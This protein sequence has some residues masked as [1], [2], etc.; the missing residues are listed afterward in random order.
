MITE[1]S[2]E[3]MLKVAVAVALVFGVRVQ[4][5]MPLQ[6]PDQP[7]NVDPELAFAVRVK[8]APEL[9]LAVHVAPQLI[10]DGVL[11]TVPVPVPAVCTVI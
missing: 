10:P 9:K 2:P 4:V 3:A 1:I 5:P 6:A 11:V 8:D 7:A